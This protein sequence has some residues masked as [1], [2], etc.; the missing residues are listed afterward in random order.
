MF[1]GGLAVAL[2]EM[3]IAGDK[4]LDA[5]AAYV[6]TRLDAALFGEAQSRIIIAA[7]PADRGA[8]ETLVR[9]LSVPIEII[10]R[11]SAGPRF[12]LGPIDLPL[13]EIRDAFEG[14]LPAA[15]AKTPPTDL[16]E[17]L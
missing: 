2:A 8:L 15:L 13:T 4:G 5:A 6:G 1:D 3:C 10:G 12:L 17:R 16:G 9:G 11:V 14:G 7:K